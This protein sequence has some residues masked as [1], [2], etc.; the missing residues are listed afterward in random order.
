MKIK[1]KP[2]DFIVEE[3]SHINPGSSGPFALYQ[4]RKYG[5][6]TTDVLDHV[7]KGHRI[8]R[9]MLQYGGRKDR[10]A[11]TTQYITVGPNC[12]VDLSGEFR[13]SPQAESFYEFRLLGA[14]GQPMSPGLI[15]AN[16]FHVVV[17]ELE[18]AEANTALARASSVL[19]QLGIPNYFDD[20]RF[21]GSTQRT[22]F[23]AERIMRGQWRG[24]LQSILDG[25]GYLGSLENWEDWNKL[26][27]KAKQSWVRRICTHLQQNPQD[28]LG[29]LHLIPQDELA[30]HYAAFQAYIWNE[31]LRRAMISLD[32]PLLA[33]P[34][35]AGPYLFFDP[36]TPDHRHAIERLAE[37]LATL[38]GPKASFSDELLGK[39]YLEVLADCGVAP[40]DFN[41]RRLRKVFFKAT[42]R[43]LLVTPSH[44]RVSGPDP[45]DLHPGKFKLSLEF[46]LPRGSYGTMVVKSL[47]AKTLEGGISSGIQRFG[48]QTRQ[49]T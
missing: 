21:R 20:Q 27:Q 24:A 18:L 42:P 35:D 36:Q 25:L 10:W 1:T 41:V 28:Y 15:A 34:G 2:E 31:L 11:I 22:G 14:I 3:L 23:A 48:S 30:I 26:S 13:S 33:Y 5:W 19:L 17:R 40:P 47:F 43:S 45:D 4:L 39:L 7:A 38:P 37:S 12:P 9:R 46:S 32:V 16:S 29:A 8:P 6:N 44:L 49:Y